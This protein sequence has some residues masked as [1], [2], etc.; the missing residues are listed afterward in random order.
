M[1][2]KYFLFQRDAVTEFSTV[3]S[4][5]G[6]GLSVV[7]LP[8]TKL[9]NVTA[10]PG[11]VIM[12]FDDA[13]IYD[14]VFLASTEGMPKARIDIPCEVGTE[15]ALI[16]QILTFLTKEGG[17][18]VMRFDA[19]TNTSTFSLVDFSREL[20]KSKLPN[21]P[22]LYS[23]AIA[24]DPLD[25]GKIAPDSGV[26]TTLYAGVHFPNPSLRPIVD[27]NHEGLSSISDL[28]EVGQTNTWD[29]AGTG[30]ATYDLDSNVGAPFKQRKPINNDGLIESSVEI[31]SGETL[32]LANQL[33]V[34]GSYTIYMVYS[35]DSVRDMYPIYGMGNDNAKG[36]GAGDASDTMVFKHN[37]AP[38]TTN[39]AFAN[40]SGTDYNTKDGYVQDR[41]LD[42]ATTDALR[43]KLKPQT[44][45]VWVIRRDDNLNMYVHDYTGEVVGFVPRVW[46]GGSGVDFATD[47]DLEIDRIGGT[48]TGRE[49]SGNLARFGVVEDD[50]GTADAARIARELYDIYAY[51]PSE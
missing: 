2:E 51:Y 31:D 33:N 17:K 35:I 14:D 50:V 45:Y 25:S 22:V 24:S 28:A 13:G 43:I 7:A 20:V 49:W 47:G 8:A 40:I 27:Y 21:Q 6:D 30:G 23:G 39:L 4:N 29:N 5:T 19:V 36:F 48:G 26:S 10:Q 34:T 37:Q 3:A 41:L 15:V 16:E 38:A 44:C 18:S 32:I 46:G 9:A 1:A 42:T 12:R 11:E